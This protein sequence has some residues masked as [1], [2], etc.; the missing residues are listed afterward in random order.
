MS[1]ARGQ[2]CSAGAR[3]GHRSFETWTSPDLGVL[4]LDRRPPPPLPLDVLGDQWSKGAVNAAEAAACPVDYVVAPLLA[5]ASALIGN[6]RWPQAWPDWEEP[7]H[8]WCC[9]V[10]DSGC[11]KSPGADS[12]MR[13][14]VPQLER[15][16]RA[17]FPDKLREHQA[18]V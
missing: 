15:R 8:L 10:G 1:V 2:V 9:S 6:A 14:V 17:D 4:R 13:H 3:D 5:S 12:L 16:M 7:P 11:G 18:A